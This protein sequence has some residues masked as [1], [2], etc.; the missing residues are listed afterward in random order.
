MRGFR[1]KPVLKTIDL[2]KLDPEK[3]E[4]FCTTKHIDRKRCSLAGIEFD[5]VLADMMESSAKYYFIVK[6]NYEYDVVPGPLFDKLNEEWKLIQK[7]HISDKA[8]KC[9]DHYIKALK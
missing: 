6:T 3:V 2:R 7:Q 8:Q 1:F 5:E 4:Y 9:I